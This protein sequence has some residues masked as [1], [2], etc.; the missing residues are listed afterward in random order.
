MHQLCPIRRMNYYDSIIF[1]L[2]KILPLESIITAKLGKLKTKQ[3]I[4]TL[5]HNWGHLGGGGNS[6]PN[7]PHSSHIWSTVDLGSWC[8]SSFGPPPPELAHS[9]SKGQGGTHSAR[10]LDPTRR[11][12]CGCYTQLEPYSWNVP[13]QRTP[14]SATWWR[15]GRRR[16]RVATAM[17]CGESGKKGEGKG[18]WASRVEWERAA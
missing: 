16:G 10:R 8:P 18:K 15:R 14:R 11:W 5:A 7:W 13:L 9:P 1:E 4:R 6:T 12:Q 3:Q 17:V 2:L